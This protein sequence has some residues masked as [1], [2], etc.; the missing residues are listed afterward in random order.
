MQ[1]RAAEGGFAKTVERE[2]RAIAEDAGVSGP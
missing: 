2:G 1:A